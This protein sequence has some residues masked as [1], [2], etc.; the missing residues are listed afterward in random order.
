MKNALKDWKQRNTAIL[1]V[2]GE[3]KNEI[4]NSILSIIDENGKAGN[5]LY[6][7][8]FKPSPVGFNAQMANKI[9]KREYDV[10]KLIEIFEK[11]LPYS[12][13]KKTKK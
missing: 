6:P 11:L 5:S 13:P 1:K 12:N 8:K 10:D 3:L 4:G 2:T 7:T 9:S